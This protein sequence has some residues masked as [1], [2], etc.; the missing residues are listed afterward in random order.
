MKKSTTP[1][2]NNFLDREKMRE[3]NQIVRAVETAQLVVHVQDS[4][5]ILHLLF[6]DR[7]YKIVG[8]ADFH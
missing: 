1:A 5:G 7:R 3:Y 4:I 6:I 2:E 8:V